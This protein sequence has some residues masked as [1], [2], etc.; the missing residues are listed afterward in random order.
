VAAETLTA[1]HGGQPDG[2]D[3]VTT[4][5]LKQTGSNHV[6]G[7]TVSVTSGSPNIT[8]SANGF[9]ASDVGRAVTTTNTSGRKIASV[10]NAGAAVMDGNATA[11]SGPQALTLAPVLTNVT[12]KTGGY[13]DKTTAFLPQLPTG[14][15]HQA[16]RALN[17]WSNCAGSGTTSTRCQKILAAQGLFVQET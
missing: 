5:Q 2:S 13:T 11:S 7:A 10:T 6:F 17:E 16:Q 4:T 14:A 15:A 8:D 3:I 12:K 1:H 9:V